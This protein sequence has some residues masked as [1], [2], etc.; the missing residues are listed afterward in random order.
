MGRF[1]TG[2]RRQKRT[3]AVVPVRIRIDGDQGSQPAHTLD[4]SEHGVKLSGIRSELKVGDGIEVSCR[5]KRARFRVIWVLANP[6]S[7]EKQVGAECC[8]PEKGI[9]G[10]ELP[11]EAD[12]YEEKN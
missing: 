9:W 7:S 5:H 3:R 1:R 10:A 11:N 12:E 2:K 4:F 8:E 6:G